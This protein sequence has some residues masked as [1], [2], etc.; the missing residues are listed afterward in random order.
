[1]EAGDGVMIGGFIITGTDSKRV[2]IRGIGP[3]LAAVGVPGAI[4]DPILRLFGSSG[5]QLGVNDNW[6]DTQQAE[7]AATG[8]PPQDARE[9]AIV[10]T[11]M[12][13]AFTAT[14]ADANGGSGVGLVEVYDLNSAAGARLANIST[15][16]SVQIEDN[17]MIGGFALGGS[18]INPA[19]VVVRALGPSLAGNGI[20][21][22]LSNPT[23]QLF[24][25]NG[26]SVGFNDNWQD[27]PSQAAQLQTLS[28]EPPNASEAAL[29]ATLPPGLYTAVVAGQDGGVG[30]GLIEVYAIQ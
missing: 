13:G 25:N 19:K 28:L 10:A 11:L 15:R 30:I 26:Q 4:S 5:S 17:V 7:I 12:P 20:N 1:V 8:I 9:A 2:I 29:V 16:G 27:D 22:P 14:L 21:N 23:L 6:Q 18:S 24:D 3:S